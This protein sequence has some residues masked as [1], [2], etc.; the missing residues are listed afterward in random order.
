MRGEVVGV[1]AI[2]IVPKSDEPWAENA[3]CRIPRPTLKAKARRWRD[4]RRL[5]H[6][7][8]AVKRL[9]NGRV[10]HIEDARAVELIECKGEC[11]IRI[12]MEG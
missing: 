11:Y 4:K 6:A 9:F 10:P 3:C 5:R 2:E 7:M 8:L 12:R 1:D